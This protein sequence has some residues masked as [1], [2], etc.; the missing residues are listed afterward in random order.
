[1]AR[2]PILTY[3]IGNTGYYIVADSTEYRRVWGI[4]HDIIA[5]VSNNVRKYGFASHGCDCGFMESHVQVREADL[6]MY[7]GMLINKIPF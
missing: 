5:R 2:K 3:I 1:V 6:R 7:L 4:R